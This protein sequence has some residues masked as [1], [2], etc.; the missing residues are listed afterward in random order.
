MARI[1]A[2]VVSGERGVDT[3]AP[4]SW[5]RP[6]ARGSDPAAH[7]ADRPG[8]RGAPVSATCRR[9]AR[10]RRLRG[11]RRDGGA[12]RRTVPARPGLRGAA[13]PTRPAPG[14]ASQPVARPRRRRP[15]APAASTCS[16]EAPGAALL[17]MGSD[18]ELGLGLGFEG[19]L[20]GR[21]VAGDLSTG[22]GWPRR[23]FA[24]AADGPPVTLHRIP[25]RLGFWIPI[26]R[27]APASWSRGTC[28]H[29]FAICEAL[30]S[31]REP[32]R[33]HLLDARSE[34][35]LC[36]RI[37]LLRRLFARVGVSSGPEAAMM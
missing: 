6:A 24:T 4:A 10:P 27:P 1:P 16:R 3:R 33:P 36:F 21:R 34:L 31:R 8:G 12:D 17:P 19:G 18:F 14:P 15:M 26:S 25:V 37:N 5:R 23:A 29:G 35:V 20:A 13:E 7:R 30:A 22:F 2:V 9:R 32:C 11:A 28:W